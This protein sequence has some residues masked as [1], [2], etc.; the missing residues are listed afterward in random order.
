MD[1]GLG[2]PS[3][4]VSASSSGSASASISIDGK[5]K[6]ASDSWDSKDGAPSGG[7]GTWSLTSVSQKTFLRSNFHYLSVLSTG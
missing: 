4:N 6:T 1:K 3:P 5:T 7:G 2:M